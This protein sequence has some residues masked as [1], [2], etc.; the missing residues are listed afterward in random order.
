MPP[1]KKSADE[2]P[3]LLDITAKLRSGPCVPALR[4]AVKA[5]KDADCKGITDTTR[6]LLNYWFRTDHKLKTG[7]LFKYHESQQEGIETLIYVWEVEK[8]RTRKH[9]LEKYAQNVADLRL[10]PDDS[11]AR[12]C[13]KMATGSGKTKV[14]ALA[15]AWQYFN[16]VR[17]QDEIAKD[18]A[19]T[20][21]LIAPNVIVLERLKA[22]FAA[23]R[24]FREDPSGRK[25]STF[26]GISIASCGAK[27]SERIL[28]AF[29]SSPTFIN[30]TN[31]LTARRT[32]NRTR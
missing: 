2:T 18:Y 27:G 6:T 21:L 14:M 23:G 20:Y 10:P 25:S 1:R 28:K 8:I 30:F 13:T 11:F 16:A 26:S 19:K 15:I 29:S 32:M 3:S 7:R 5:W 9:L 17:E 24:I 22:D 12:Y 4:Q 31:E